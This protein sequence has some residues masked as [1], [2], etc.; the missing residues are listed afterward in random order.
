MKIGQVRVSGFNRGFKKVNKL[1]YK[2][3]RH[4][5]I[6][7]T[8]NDFEEDLT[9]LWNM[10]NSQDSESR[11]FAKTIIKNQVELCIVDQS[12]TDTTS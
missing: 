4:K 9:A 11:D 8:Q 5:V 10:Y 12:E 2:L 6:Y 1:V 3:S 7:L